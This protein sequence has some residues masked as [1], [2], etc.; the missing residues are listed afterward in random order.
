V[1]DGCTGTLP[2]F[3]E[4]AVANKK[5]IILT[6]LQRRQSKANTS[7]S[8]IFGA[9]RAAYC[10]GRRR[11]GVMVKIVPRPSLPPSYVVPKN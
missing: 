7:E 10:R 11:Y 5:T 3:P 1:L 9:G 6:M 8:P 2:A 4:H